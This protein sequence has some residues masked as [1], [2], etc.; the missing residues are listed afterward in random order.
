MSESAIGERSTVALVRC[1]TYD[2]Q[3]VR[4]AVGRGLDLLGGAARFVSPGETLL[5]KPNFLVASVPEAAVTTHPAVF[6][7]VA[8]H[9]QAAGATLTYGDSP[10]F[11]SSRGA[12]RRGGLEP[13]AQELEIAP[14]DFS[15]GSK[16]SFTEGSLIKQFTIAQGVLDA[17]GIVSLP[18]LKTHGLTRMTGAIKNQFG[19]IPGVLKGEF[20]AKVP[21]AERFSRM[22]VDLNG[23]LKP[24]LFVMDGIVGMEGNGPR[25]GT[26]RPMRCLI[27]SDDPVAVDATVCR[28]IGLDPELVD[29]ITIGEAEGLG[30]YRDVQVVGDAIEALAQPDFDVNRRP[31]STTGGDGGGAF[32]RLFKTLVVPRPVVIPENCTK[33]GTCVQ[34]CPVTPKA[35][36]WP[37]GDRQTPPTHR[38]DDCIRC[39]CCQELCPHEA[40]TTQTPLLGRLVRR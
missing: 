25:G 23:A 13:I 5:L 30:R 20:H 21:S 38:Y 24:R 16:V 11:G 10:G 34:V 3:D 22:L 29:C 7:A 37:N 33:C 27:L 35:I 32:A 14:A 18:K 4:D 40:I 15:Q 31:G 9:L 39:Y 1:D 19:C 26:P 6:D 12:A 2:A 8:R 28:L 17:D 36:D